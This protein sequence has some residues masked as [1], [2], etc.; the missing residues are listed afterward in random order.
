MD[1]AR[2]VPTWGVQNRWLIFRTASLSELRDGVRYIKG[3]SIAPA[4]VSIDSFLACF[5]SLESVGTIDCMVSHECHMSAR[6][7]DLRKYGNT[8]RC[9]VCMDPQ[10]C[11]LSYGTI[12]YSI[13]LYCFEC[14][15]RYRALPYNSA[16]FAI[17]PRHLRSRPAK[18]FVYAIRHLFVLICK[19][20]RDFSTQDALQH[21]VAVARGSSER[22]L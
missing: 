10:T 21:R 6:A 22:P 17:L 2:T 18:S 5:L 3:Q 15:T 14:R 19:I 16:S 1:V 4:I 12:L 13:A 7:W 20:D 9:C 8:S 11:G